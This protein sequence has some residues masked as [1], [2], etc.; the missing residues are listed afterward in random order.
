MY[1]YQAFFVMR[2]ALGRASWYHLL[3]SKGQGVLRC[4]IGH[5]DVLVSPLIQWPSPEDLQLIQGN[6]TEQVLTK[7]P[8]ETLS[9]GASC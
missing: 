4:P 9:T 1:G 8:G 2:H 7:S 5:E 6:V 3:A